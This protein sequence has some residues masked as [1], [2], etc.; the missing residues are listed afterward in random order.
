LKTYSTRASTNAID[1][2]TITAMAGMLA[3]AETVRRGDLEKPTEP[4]K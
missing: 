2:D 3:G 1:Y 4:E